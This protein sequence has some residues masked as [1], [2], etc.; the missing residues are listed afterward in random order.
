MISAFNNSIICKRIGSDNISAGGAIRTSSEKE[1]ALVVE[2][3]S[4]DHS[5]VEAGDTFVIARYSGMELPYKG[6]DLLFLTIDDLVGKVEDDD[7]K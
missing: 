6:A 1:K 5:S 7:G 3:V 4:S 2:V